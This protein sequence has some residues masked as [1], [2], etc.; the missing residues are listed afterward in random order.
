MNPEE[1]GLKP[2]R[3]DVVNLDQRPVSEM[4]PEEQGLKL[5]NHLNEIRNLGQSQR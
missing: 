3:L 5:E 4:N 2:N 1:Q